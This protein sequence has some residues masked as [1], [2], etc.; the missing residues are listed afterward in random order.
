MKLTELYYKLRKVLLD[1]L[2]WYLSKKELRTLTSKAGTDIDKIY[3][4]LKSYSGRGFYSSIRATQS[5]MEFKE[6]AKIVQKRSPR[7]VLEI[8]S[9]KGGT[10]F[11]W[12]RSNPSIEVAISLDL[13]DGKFGGGYERRRKKLYKEFIWDRRGAKMFLVRDDSHKPETL[14]TV[15][16]TL[17]GRS[18]DF[19]FIDGD[20]SYEGVRQD[21]E[22]Y[23]PLV[24]EG[25]IVAF[26]DIITEGKGHEVW[27]F[28]NELKGGFNS[29]EIIE[30]PTRKKFGIGVIYK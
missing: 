24:V 11:M 28:W 16:N 1:P 22:M 19:L 12:C 27:R 17:A 14:A 25:G 30:N 29:R 3:C 2:A 7:V 18:I 15:R 20:H 8:G 26:H 4:S 21:F 9:Y 6:L 23:W 10:L 13:P 5:E